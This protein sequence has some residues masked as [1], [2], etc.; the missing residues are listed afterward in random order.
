MESPYAKAKA[1]IQ[2]SERIHPE[3]VALHHGYGHTGFG[4][5]AQGSLNK[6]NA[7]CP[8]GTNDGQFLAGVSEITSGM[9]VH[10]EI[11]VKIIKA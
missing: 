7:W 10:K 5:I 4:K 1:T 3:V 8:A 9:A 11:G 6:T 2:V